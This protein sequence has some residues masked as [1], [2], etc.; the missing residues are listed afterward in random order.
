M[1]RPRI[2]QQCNLSNMHLR[3]SILHVTRLSSKLLQSGRSFSVSKPLHLLIIVTPT[4][5]TLARKTLPSVGGAGLRLGDT[6]K[7]VAQF[8]MVA[9]GATQGSTLHRALLRGKLSCK[10]NPKS[11]KQLQRHGGLLSSRKRLAD[12]DQGLKL[13]EAYGIRVS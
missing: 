6:A 11:G 1:S 2:G 10:G 3:R 13:T 5:G 8:D 4:R 12:G 9:S 7:P